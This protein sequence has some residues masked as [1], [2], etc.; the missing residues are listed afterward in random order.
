LCDNAA[1]K[2]SEYERS[3][4]EV[5]YEVRRKIA[6]DLEKSIEEHRNSGIQEEFILGMNR[7]MLLVLYQQSLKVSDNDLHVQ[8]KLF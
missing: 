4:Q 7:A 8:D 5:E 2:W 1:V 3:R 6:R